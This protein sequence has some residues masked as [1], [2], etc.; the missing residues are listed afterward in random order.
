MGSG[1]RVVGILIVLGVGYYVYSM[2][3][4][5]RDVEELCSTYVKG[6]R[7]D[8]ILEV[9][10]DYSGQLMGPIESTNKDDTYSFIYCAPVTSPSGRFR[11]SVFRIS[12]DL[13]FRF[14][15]VSGR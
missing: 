15:L 14:A 1:V 5:S 8:E 7:A 11:K 6:T 12:D 10:Q 13:D 9:A 4:Q 3:A 2:H